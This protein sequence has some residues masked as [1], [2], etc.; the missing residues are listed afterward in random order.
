MRK[1]NYLWKTSLVTVLIGSIISC[2][3]QSSQQE[4]H[5]TDREY[6]KITI[7]IEEGCNAGQQAATRE[8]IGKRIA[9]YYQVKEIGELK[10]GQFD[11]ICF[12]DDSLSSA[13]SLFTQRGEM[14]IAETY[15]N[16]EILSMFDIYE[17][18]PELTNLYEKLTDPISYPLEYEPVVLRV[19]LEK[20][21]YIDSIF[22]SNKNLLPQ[23]A[24]FYWTEKPHNRYYELI[25]VKLNPAE[26]VPLNPNTVKEC[27][28][29]KN[30]NTGEEIF[31]ELKEQYHKQWED[32][33]RKNIGRSLAIILD[34]KVLFYPVVSSEIT[35]GRSMIAGNFGHKELLLLQSFITN[36]V[37]DCEARIVK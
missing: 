30:R 28:I 17:K 24:V 3:R 31:M 10:N 20:V 13:L 14:Y 4:D 18:F 35:D 23:G 22:N 5:K 19:P 26:I 8:I 12:G 1:I 11:L 32:L 29:E 37:L 36:G 33:T 7:A 27:T 6:H 16:Q 21:P 25:A 9:S 34:E 2:S 15:L